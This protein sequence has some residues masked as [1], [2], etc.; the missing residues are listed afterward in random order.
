MNKLNFLF[1]RR[2]W[3]SSVCSVLF[4]ILILLIDIFVSFPI[5]LVITLRHMSESAADEL[6]IP[7]V[8]A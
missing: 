5:L 7:D 3:H 1:T 6:Q 2:C 8:M 4:S